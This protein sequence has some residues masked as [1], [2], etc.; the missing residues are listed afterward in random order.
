M[1]KKKSSPSL[2]INSFHYCS[3]CSGALTDSSITHLRAGVYQGVILCLLLTLYSIG[4]I[5]T[6]MVLTITNTLKIQK[7]LNLFPK[8]Q[9]YLT[10]ITWLCPLECLI[11]FEFNHIQMNFIK[12]LSNLLS[13]HLLQT[14]PIY[15]T[16]TYPAA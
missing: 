1:E 6:F 7:F 15:G 11:G 2:K 14:P 16:T 9:T 13:L 3:S 4:M 12:F 10:I 5:F 8:I